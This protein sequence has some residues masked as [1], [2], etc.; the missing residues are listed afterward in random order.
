ME[1][2]IALI[3]TILPSLAGPGAAVLILLLV[4]F[5]IGYL[6]QKTIIP[7]LVGSLEQHKADLQSIMLSHD[8]DRKAYMESIEKI[9]DRLEQLGDSLEDLG[10]RTSRV[11][12]LLDLDS[13][14]A[15]PKPRTKGE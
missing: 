9:T 6:L 10:D 1:S 3:Q 4:L 13:R 5:G 14:P 12:M 8:Q 11:E 2:A 7:A 15:K